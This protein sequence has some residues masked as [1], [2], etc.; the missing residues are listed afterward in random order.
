MGSNFLMVTKLVSS[1]ADNFSEAISQK[2]EDF[3]FL[4]CASKVCFISCKT[5]TNYK[6]FRFYLISGLA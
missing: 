5:Y 2:V 4:S 6:C 3:F 1:K